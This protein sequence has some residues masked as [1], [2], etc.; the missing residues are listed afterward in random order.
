MGG[1]K[2]VT[3]LRDL[4]CFGPGEVGKGEAVTLATDPL[5][6]DRLT[7]PYRVVATFEDCHEL[8]AALGELG[9]RLGEHSGVAVNTQDHTIEV[10]VDTPEC[11]VR[12]R[13]VLER[14]QTRS[15]EVVDFAGHR[16]A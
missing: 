12:A 15:L 11:A 13:E 8:R 1:S 5:A 2:A 4:P 16:I 10:P 9:V 7:R 3:I 14:H 6:T